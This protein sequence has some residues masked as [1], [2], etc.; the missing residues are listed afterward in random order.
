MADAAVPRRAPLLRQTAL[1]RLLA[2]A[3]RFILRGAPQVISKAGDALELPIE[4]EPCRASQ[5]A[6]CAA[7]WLGPDEYLLIAPNTDGRALARALGEALTSAPHSLVDVSHRQSALEVTG[8]NAADII[9]SGCPLDLHPTQFA[10]GMCTRTVLA[11][12]EI[13]LWRTAS[14][15]FHIEVWRSFTDYV[16]CFLNE[17]AS[18]F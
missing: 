14:D 15:V 18:E 2:P 11:K 16:A 17:A 3:A 8:H 7:L 9:N 4:Q 6:A 10:V 13:V 1:L 5:G 12:A